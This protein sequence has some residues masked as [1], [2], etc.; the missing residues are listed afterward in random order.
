MATVSGGREKP[1]TWDN[2]ED[3]QFSY[4]A[5][6]YGNIQT[7]CPPHPPEDRSLHGSILGNELGIDVKATSTNQAVS[8]QRFFNERDVCQDGYQRWLANCARHKSM[9]L[10]SFGT[11]PEWIKIKPLLDQ[12]DGNIP[13]RLLFVCQHV[14]LLSKVGGCKD[15]IKLEIKDGSN[16][17]DSIVSSVMN[18]EE[19]FEGATSKLVQGDTTS[20]FSIALAAFHRR[21]KVNHL[22]A[23]LE[24]TTN[25]SHIQKSLIG[26]QYLEL[27]MY[28]FALQ[29]CQ[30]CS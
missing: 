19:I 30:K 25:I 28:I 20:A 14:D 26:K 18:S 13:Y 12:M 10:L 5:R 4:L 24:H 3:I 22:E 2:G 15:L 8:H 6:K 7:Y 9:I 1:T 29:N 11:R 27:Q 17:L 23:G 21:I 16:R